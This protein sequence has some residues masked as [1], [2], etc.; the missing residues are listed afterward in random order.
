MRQEAKEWIKEAACIGNQG[1]ASRGKE[2]SK[3]E[4]IGLK[5]NHA[6]EVLKWT[7]LNH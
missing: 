1:K 4:T 2:D 3:Q 5:T 7:N 6:Q